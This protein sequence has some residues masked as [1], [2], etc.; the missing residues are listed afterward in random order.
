MFVQTI[1]TNWTLR[2]NELCSFKRIRITCL[3]LNISGSSFILLVLHSSSSFSFY[4]LGRVKRN[5]FTFLPNVQVSS[6]TLDG[7]GAFKTLL[8]SLTSPL[9]QSS[10]LLS[11]SSLFLIFSFPFASVCLLWCSLLW[12]R[13]RVSWNDFGAITNLRTTLFSS[14]TRGSS[15]EDFL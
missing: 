14:I 13:L 7:E 10:H 9:S 1:V 8:L 11:L 12:K 15:S 4:F 5:C 6:V 3:H 2:S